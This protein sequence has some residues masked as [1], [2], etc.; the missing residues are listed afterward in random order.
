MTDS[1]RDFAKFGESLVDASGQLILNYWRNDP[2]VYTKTDASPV[3]IADRR[4]E[5]TIRQMIEDEYPTHGIAGEEYGQKK[6]DAEYIWSIDPI[7]G[8]KAFISGSPLFGTLIALLKD[9]IPILGI[10]DIPA[11][12][13]RWIGGDNLPATLNGKSLQTR[14]GLDLCDATS[15]STSPKM[16]DGRDEELSLIHI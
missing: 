5:A 9:G 16:F 1:V 2:E 4:A 8:T 10:I 12:G 3:T 14:I 13:E 11:T 15:G 6:M 7:D